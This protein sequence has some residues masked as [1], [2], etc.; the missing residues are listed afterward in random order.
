MGTGCL[1]RILDR[2]TIGVLSKWRNGLWTQESVDRRPGG[3]AHLSLAIGPSTSDLLPLTGR[4]EMAY[5][6]SMTVRILIQLGRRLL[7]ALPG[8]WSLRSLRCRLAAAA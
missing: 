2:S 6:C 1:D 4:H 5:P 8:R 3:L 7:A